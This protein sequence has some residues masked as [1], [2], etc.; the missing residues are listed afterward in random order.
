MKERAP[1]AMPR[2]HLQEAD[3]SHNEEHVIWLSDASALQST[4]QFDVSLAVVG[5]IEGTVISPVAPPE[6]RHNPDVTTT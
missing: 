3:V 1:E 4:Y 6:P 5:S 2:E